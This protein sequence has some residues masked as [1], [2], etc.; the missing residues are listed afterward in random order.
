MYYII[1]TYGRS[2]RELENT[3]AVCKI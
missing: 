2:K 3:I 1:N